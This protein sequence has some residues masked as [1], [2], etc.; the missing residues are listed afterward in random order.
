MLGSV[1][2]PVKDGKFCSYERFSE[3]VIIDETNH[4][5]LDFIE[6]TASGFQTATP[7]IGAVL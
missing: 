4:S 2:V 6:K 1:K 3:V 7:D 5:G